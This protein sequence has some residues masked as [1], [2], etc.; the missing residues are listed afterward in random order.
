MATSGTASFNLDL[1]EIVEEAYERCG[2]ELRTGYDLRTARRSL[3]L[4]FA[5]W[6]SRG[7]NMWTFEEGTINLVPGVA[8]YDLPADT[9][10]LLDHVIRTGAGSV[11]TQADLTITRISVSTYATLPNKL[12][13]ARPI[14]VWVERLDTPRV[15]LWPVPDNSQ[16]Y[17]FVY[18]RLRRIQDAGD[19]VNTM[20]M[21]FRFVPCMVAGLAY[22]LSLKVPGGL[23]RMAMLKTQY[24]EAWAIASTEDREKA[25][26]RFV[27]RRM[28]IS[29]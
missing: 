6:A 21:P 18:W 22:H 8:T 2:G 28:Y 15:T 27:P 17:Q 4:M 3:N 23:E 16:Q 7:L 25:S 10:D 19:G 5:E 14:Q 26:D 1:S 13:Q 12:T 11:S 20:D 29:G 24:D 9:V